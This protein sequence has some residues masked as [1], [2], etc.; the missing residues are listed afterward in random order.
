MKKRSWIILGVLAAACLSGC[1]QKAKGTPA[2][3]R[4]AEAR[5][6]DDT[7]AYVTE[8]G[9]ELDE[10]KAEAESAE[11]LGQQFKAVALLCAAEYQNN[12]SSSNSPNLTGWVNHDVFQF[13]YPNTSAYAD[14]YFSKV[15]TDEAAFWES[16]KDAYYPYDYFLPMFAAAENLDGQTLT[17]LLGN[18]ELEGTCKTK[19]EDAIDAWVQNKPG[20]AVAVGDQLMEIGYYD[21]WGIYDWPGVYLS[22]STDL[23]RI[24]TDTAEE[25]LE[26]ILYMRNTFLPGMQSKVSKDSYCK[27]S[28]INGEEYYSTDLAVTI[29]E[30]LQLSEPR[31]DNLPETIDL[32]GKKV[33]A[34][35]HNPAAG[36]DADAPPAWRILGDFIMGLPDEE[37][38]ATLADADYYLVLTSDHQFGNYYQDQSGN[39]TKIQAVYS[40]TSLDLYDAATG[41]FLRHIGKIIENPSTRIIKDLGEESAQYPEL[42]RADV[43]SYIYHN[44]NDPD[45]YLVLLDNSSDLE[46]LQPGGSG[47]LGVWEI[48]MNSVEVIKSFESGMFSYSASDGCQFVRG[49]FS[50]TNRGFQN[51]SFLAGDLHLTSGYAMFAGVTD[52]S[53]ENYYPA[54]DAMTYSDCLNGKS[55]EPGETKEG[56]VLFEVPDSA[57]GGPNPLYMV[58]NI[59]NQM[60]TC[61]IE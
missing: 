43:L 6:A 33:A 25:G 60:L 11:T 45:S 54:V 15:N 18:T 19:L 22:N 35:Y 34:F 7:F 23:Y 39:E 32:E 47:L 58:F 38:P 50:V 8:H 26:Y 61:A 51:D 12:L 27:T 48:T 49:H 44:I 41:D 53:G 52:E 59:G 4:W 57:I 37:I 56:V 31:E 10:L 17:K 3:V 30:D 40:S 46:P 13:D 42:T 16:L 28:D 55:F 5:K 36:E 2:E 21:G 29:K 14:A 1:S 20:K 24:Q 9:E